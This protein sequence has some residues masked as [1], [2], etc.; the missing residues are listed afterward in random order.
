MKIEC[1]RQKFRQTQPQNYPC[2]AGEYTNNFES[3][4]KYKCMYNNNN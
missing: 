3:N 4:K 1:K 2:G